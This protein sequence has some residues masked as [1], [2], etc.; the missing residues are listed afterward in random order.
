MLYLGK[1]AKYVRER[2]RLTLRDAASQLGISHA[3]LSN[4]ENNH[5][6]PSIQL[7]EVFQQVYGVDLVVL[8]WCLYGDPNLLPT[9]VREPMERLADAWKRELGD[10][11]QK[12]TGGQAR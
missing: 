4:I 8:A 6:T 2:K 12:S 11:A 5:A 10:I 3:H 9:A 7:L 1:T